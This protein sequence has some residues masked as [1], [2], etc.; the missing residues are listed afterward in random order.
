MSTT[1]AS[2]TGSTDGRSPEEIRDRY[3]E[4]GPIT[5]ALQL[6]LQGTG[7]QIVVGIGSRRGVGIR[8]VRMAIG[9][10]LSSSGVRARDVIAIATVDAKQSEEALLELADMLNIPLRFLPADV[11]AGQNV[12]NPS[13]TTE[14]LAGVP[15]VAEA[16]VL[17]S[18]AELIGPKHTYRGVT[19]AVGRMTRAVPPQQHGWAA[20]SA[21][22]VGTEARVYE[23]TYDEAYIAEDLGHHGDAEVAP[24]LVDL[25]VNVRGSAP[26]WLQQRLRDA[27]TDLAAYPD[28]RAATEAI[29]ARH[30]RPA[31]QVLL[32]SG[33]AE[34]FVLLARALAPHRAVVIHPQFTEPEAALL[35]AGHEVQRVVLAPP[36]RID[37]G[38][39]PDDA[40]LVMVGN[41]TN[42]TS[43][44]HPAETLIALSR[45]GRVLV[46]D[47][48]FMDA[49]PG[50][51]QSL[52]GSPQRPAPDVPGLV[53]VRS[54]TKSWGL[55]GL[56]VGYLLGAP[57]L[58]RACAATQSLWA[59]NSLAVEAATA[60]TTPEA[61]AEAQTFAAH[62]AEDREHLVR[63]L[64]Q[65]PDVE[66]QGPASAPF[67]LLRAGGPDP[68]GVHQRLREAGW[69]VRR[70]DTF[71]G[72]GSGW[73]RVAVRDRSTSQQFAVALN[74]AVHG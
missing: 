52:A 47:E 8:D 25:A 16:A 30:G 15:S 74:R 11:L 41:P 35:A 18:D 1:A 44:L 54:L 53:V 19:V 29:A 9:Q 61:L 55:A 46:V 26:E 20:Q 65:V 43:V 10:A 33:G 73:M 32:T 45:P 57:E 12:P 63:A 64:A 67:V 66:V 13:A 21:H 23:Q 34:A 72:L 37:P 31:D 24:G 49:V 2:D 58:L 38:L 7:D 40:D 56:R 36:F 68:A 22:G 3:N 71:P 28:P 42:P 27:V 51:S 6:G 69:A 48:A 60:V 50:E 17:A 39:V 62:Q 59:V 70:A 5:G 4:I 14:R